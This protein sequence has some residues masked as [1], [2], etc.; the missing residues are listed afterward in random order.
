[1][2]AIGVSVP[3][4]QECLSYSVGEIWNQNR[5]I[6]Y[7]EYY[8][9]DGLVSRSYILLLALYCRNYSRI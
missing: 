6:F 5:N 4:A 9:I 8:R 2:V 7:G 3:P 1:M